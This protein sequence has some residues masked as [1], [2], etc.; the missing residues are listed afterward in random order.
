MN[1]TKNGKKVE[2]V[3][4]KHLLDGTI[5]ETIYNPITE[6]TKLLI[7]KPDGTVEEPLEDNPSSRNYGPLFDDHIKRGRVL[8][9]SQHIECDDPMELLRDVQLAIHKYVE[10][11]PGFQAISA[12]FV[13]M[14]WVY[15]RFQKVPYIR[16]LGPYGSGKSRY[17]DVMA[18]LCYHSSKL[19]EGI[20][21]ANIYRW[22]DQYPGT[23]FLDEADFW[24]TD[25]KN[26]ITQILNG[27]NSRDGGVSR[28]DGPGFKPRL[29]SSFAPKVLASRQ[30]YMDDALE[31]RFLTHNSYEKTRS[32][33][34]LNVPAFFEWEEMIIL[35]NRLLGFRLKYL[36][37]IDTDM[38]INDMNNYEPRMAEII[39]P[40]F[41]TTG[42]K[43]IPADL[44]EF[45]D[46]QNEDRLALMGLT[47]DGIFAEVI[48]NLYENNDG[49][50]PTIKD[51]TRI[52]NQRREPQF[53]LSARKVGEIVRG[54]SL[55]THREGRGYVVQGTP[56]QLEW[57]AKRYGI[58][59]G[60]GQDG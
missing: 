25:K 6:N 7:V 34:P 46:G 29:Y 3:L 18:S 48:L 60:N 36:H 17:L 53:P 15:E 12:R 49:D 2:K 10:V 11:G 28:C 21:P 19:G 42:E 41:Q 1:K 16:V 22:L 55:R 56:H 8:L 45:L 44:K 5:I 23:L 57:I 39:L 31:S 13:L 4:G 50:N 40:L 14:T 54:L 59:G 47:D 52:G 37:N 9:P 43:I 27:G 33:I 24:G 20:T 30:P 38:L 35:R 32:D 58:N 26:V 51:V